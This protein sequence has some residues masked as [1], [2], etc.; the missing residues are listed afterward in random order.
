M[1]ADFDDEYADVWPRTSGKQISSR[2][3]AQPNASRAL[4][5]SAPRRCSARGREFARRYGAHHLA[6]PAPRLACGYDAA[7]D[8]YV[9]PAT[10]LRPLL[11]PRPPITLAATPLCRY[12]VPAPTAERCADVRMLRFLAYMATQLSDEQLLQ[13]STSPGYERPRFAQ[14]QRASAEA[15]LAVA[16]EAALRGSRE[17]SYASCERTADGRYFLVP[18]L[19][20]VEAVV[21]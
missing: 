5:C 21:E 6:A 15:V 16:R 19:L 10:T 8:A 4:R 12:L 13:H 7:R 18:R 11:L 20:P 14:D 17:A 1:R 2:R 3:A 9:V